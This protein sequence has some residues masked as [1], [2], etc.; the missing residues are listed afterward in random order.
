M[1]RGNLALLLHHLHHEAACSRAAL[2]AVSGLSRSTVAALVADLARRGLVAEE[3]PRTDGQRG[4]PSPVVRLQPERVVALAVDIEVE[5]VAVATYGLGGSLLA[6]ERVPHPQDPADPARVVAALEPLLRR[7]RAA[8]RSDQLLA[9]V[10][11]AIAGVV[12]E[13]DGLVHICPNLGWREAHLGRLVTEALGG[14]EVPVQVGNE[15]DLGAVGEWRRGAGRGLRDLV[16]LSSEVG[17]GAGV[18]SAGRPFAGASGYA[19]EVGHLPVNPTGLRCRCGG[20]GCW[21][22]EVASEALVRHATARGV[23]A[24][25][26][27][28]VLDAAAAGDAQAL[29]AV[30]DIAWWAGRG[31]AGLVNIFNPERIVLGGVLA[32]V[33]CLATQPLHAALAEHALACARHTVEIVPG[34]LGDRAQLIGAAERALTPVLDDPTTVPYAVPATQPPPSRGVAPPTSAAARQGA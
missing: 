29:A 8:L 22:T 21:E 4:R 31:L 7:Q 32:R 30:G 18:I 19:G 23:T 17:V 12:R 5:T 10:G 34:A 2:T 6:V 33:A 25:T 1:R 9:G 24:R 20:L 28:A 27:G 26:A 16:Y 13:H 15:A 14:P 3:A 11:V